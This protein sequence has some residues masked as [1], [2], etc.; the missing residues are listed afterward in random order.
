MS[1][2]LITPPAEMAVPLADVRMDLREPDAALNGQITAM[3]KAFTEEAEHTTGRAFV[4]QTWQL[5]LDAFPD[6]IRLDPAPLASVTSI[7]YYDTSN[8]LQTIDPADY[9]VDTITEPGYVV[10]GVAKAWPETYDRINAVIVEYVV[11]Y[12]AD[13]TAVPE[14]IR[15]YIRAKVVEQFD[16]A[17]TPGKPHTSSYMDSLLDKYVVYG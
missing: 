6:A 12:G 10:P 17:P 1:A 2:K 7:K 8:V 4:N 13:S 5:Y 9:L 14:A 3:I 11:G 15:M 16:V